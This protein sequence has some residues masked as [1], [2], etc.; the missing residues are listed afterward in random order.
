MNVYALNQHFSSMKVHH[1]ASVVK[2]MHKWIPTYSTLC[3]QGRE[4][5]PLCPQCKSQIETWN[6][7]YS[8]SDPTAMEYHRTALYSFLSTM[9]QS[10][11]P[12]YILTT[13]EYKLSIVL[14][15]PFQP[16]FS[17]ISPIQPLTKIRL[18]EAIR[19]QNIVGW[20]NSY[21]GTHLATGS[22]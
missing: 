19:H 12:I 17:V 22:T 2:M 7:V 10:G 9:A 20:D 16:Q 1:R 21:V 3:R 15:I 4:S 11:A 6:H 13:F 8:C 18:I 14:A 5:S